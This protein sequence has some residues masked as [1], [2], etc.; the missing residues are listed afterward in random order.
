MSWPECESQVKGFVGARFKAFGTRLEAETALNGDYIQYAGKPSTLGKW[1]TAR[2]RP[3]LPSLCV[4]AACS[5]SPGSLEYQGVE[6]E[7]GKRIFH[8]GPFADGTNNIGE[9]L[10]IVRA[11]DY[12]SETQARLAD[13]LRF[14]EC[15][16]L[17]ESR[18]VQHQT[19]ASAIEYDVVRIDLTR[20]EDAA[21]FKQTS[22]S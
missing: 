6:T 17:G 9:F 8:A 3:I 19:G 22:V 1:K 5:G 10:A 2:V 7:S 4:D 13:L 18:K 12:L 16:R 15:H 11:M 20:R 14:G 21:S